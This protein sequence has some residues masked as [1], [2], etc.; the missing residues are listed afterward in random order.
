MRRS[1]CLPWTG[2]TSADRSGELHGDRLELAFERGNALAKLVVVEL[3]KH[4]SRLIGEFCQH[5]ALI[6]VEVI[7]GGMP[8]ISA[9]SPVVKIALP[10]RSPA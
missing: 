2:V 7:A 3:H 5:G 8:S 4:T 10:R 1:I 6:T 9:K